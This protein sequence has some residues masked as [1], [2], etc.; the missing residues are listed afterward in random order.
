MHRGL[1]THIA[2]AILASV[3]SAFV[4]RGDASA[5]TGPA[6]DPV[7]VES[8]PKAAPKPKKRPR[9]PVK[10]PTKVP[11]PDPVEAKPAEP[12]PAVTPTATTAVPAPAAPTTSPVAPAPEPRPTEPAP[13]VLTPPVAPTAPPAS[14]ASKPATP[15]A[16]T[17]APEG[18]VA[19]H[20]G[21]RYRLGVL[22]QPFVSLFARGGSTYLFHFVGLEL[23]ARL[24]GFSITSALA[25]VD[26]A[27]AG[28]ALGDRNRSGPG[29]VSYVRSDLKAVLA[30]VDLAW[31]FSLSRALDAEVGL[32]LGLGVPFGDLV[33][34]WVY[35]APDGPLVLGTKRYAACKTV[36]DGIGCRPQDHASATPIR[37]NGYVE[38]GWTSGGSSP[39]VIP[40][41]AIPQAALRIRI[42]HT[43]AMRVG[44]G[45]ATTGLWVGLGVTR[46]LSSAQHEQ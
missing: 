30:T 2:L 21:A 44:F 3:A 43:L 34:N 32:G 15:P 45:L 38:R 8:L 42:S 25:Y 26:L 37:V 40:W 19:L 14:E 22:P 27:T 13:S 35:E 24:R 17:K 33:N 6:P 9:R 39:T 4:P 16:D 28:G 5:Q 46:A 11:A 12:A 10:R 18:N 29:Y 36:N 7:S 1:R 20:L 41:V 31:T 23:D